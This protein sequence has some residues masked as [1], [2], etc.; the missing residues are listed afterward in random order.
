MT[1]T[2]DEAPSPTLSPHKSASVAENSVQ[3][4]Q[5]PEGDEADG[6]PAAHLDQLKRF[7]Q[8]MTLLFRKSDIENSS[9]QASG[10]GRNLD[11]LDMHGRVDRKLK[12]QIAKSF[13]E[14]RIKTRL[15]EQVNK[16]LKTT[17]AKSANSDSPGKASSPDA[18]SE[19]EMS[20]AAPPSQ[21]GISRC[22]PIFEE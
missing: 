9:L 1:E 20:E 11:P 8:Q 16:Q 18:P 10:A 19:I 5:T 12:G 6:P 15:A 21:L 3:T 7:E 14:H 17:R 13:K 4:D 2:S 22:A